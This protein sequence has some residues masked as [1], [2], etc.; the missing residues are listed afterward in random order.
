MMTADRIT[1]KRR[2]RIWK[3]IKPYVLIGPAIFFIF[4]FVVYPIVCQI[5]ISFTDWNLI[6]PKNHF[7]G[8]K[9][10][11]ALFTSRDF[12]QVVGNTVLYTVS[13]VAATLALALLLAFWLSNNTRINR[14]VQ[15][16]IFLPHITALV[17]VAMMFM[18]LMD[19]EI[20]VFNYVLGVLGL[21]KLQWLESSKTSMLS[22]VIVNV[23]KSLGYYTLVLLAALRG[24]PQELYEAAAL[25][26]ASRSR[27]FF[28]ITIP[29]ISPT[30]FFLL[31]V[32]T[33]LSFNVFDTVSVMTGGGPVNSTNVLVY[34][35]YKNAFTYMKVGYASAAGTVLLVIVG[36]LT[37]FYFKLLDKKVYYR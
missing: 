17:S 15:S 4:V 2:E 7:V 10:Y 13:F 27:S 9:N 33:I 29:M 26:N 28:K 18:W 31:V 22:I 3:S 35:I 1:G 30:L 12:R 23:W 37:F 6:S 14:L 11:E 36:F 25:D 34:F 24:V 19:P 8:L 32:M 20:G 21:P 16:V 5:A